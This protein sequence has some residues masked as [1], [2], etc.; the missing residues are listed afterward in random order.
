MSDLYLV[1]LAYH[2]DNPGDLAPS[3]TRIAQYGSTL[4]VRYDGAIRQT[5]AGQHLDPAEL[6][7]ISVLA[8]LSAG[9]TVTA[10]VRD[11]CRF[12]RALKPQVPPSGSSAFVARDALALLVARETLALVPGDGAPVPRAGARG[13]PPGRGKAARKGA[14]ATKAGRG[15]KGGDGESK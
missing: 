4:S 11:A 3:Q 6:R 12:Y 15:K 8:A 14:G 13:T 7:Y 5:L 9:Q 1:A 2:S 10:Q